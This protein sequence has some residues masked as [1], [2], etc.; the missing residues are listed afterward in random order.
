VGE[1]IP[2]AEE[3]AYLD[4]GCGHTGKRECVHQGQLLHPVGQGSQ[5]RHDDSGPRF[6]VHDG[7]VHDLEGRDDP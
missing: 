3:K 2:K 6:P 1:W 5:G 7:K 4:D